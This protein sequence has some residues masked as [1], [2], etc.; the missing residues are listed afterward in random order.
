MRFGPRDE[1]GEQGSRGWTICFRCAGR[2]WGGKPWLTTTCIFLILGLALLSPRAQHQALLPLDDE[3][4]SLRS[5]QASGVCWVVALWMASSF[6]SKNFKAVK[7]EAT[8]F[9]VPFNQTHTAGEPPFFHL[10]WFL[11]WTEFHANNSWHHRGQI[12]E[13]EVAHQWSNPYSTCLNL[14]G[15]KPEMVNACSRSSW[16]VET[17]RFSGSRMGPGTPSMWWEGTPLTSCVCS[18]IGR[19]HLPLP[20]QW[21]LMWCHFWLNLCFFAFRPPNQPTPTII[22]LCVL[23]GLSGIGWQPPWRTG[24]GRLGSAE[25][26]L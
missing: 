5:Q 16:F 8:R 9:G 13:A 2:D 18:W 3:M 20:I 7:A 24:Q 11:G 17:D 1:T 21:R 23:S 4:R 10:D 14:E 6:S 22:L 25:F 15:S 12:S 26:I 19:W